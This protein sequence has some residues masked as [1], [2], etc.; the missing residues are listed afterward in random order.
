MLARGHDGGDG[1]V[2]MN[3]DYYDDLETRD[4]EARERA[5]MAALC[6]QVANAKDNG[7][8]W[9]EI[10]ADVD[11]AK[12]ALLE[13]AD[14][15]GFDFQ[16]EGQIGSMANLGDLAQLIDR[17]SHVVSRV[18]AARMIKRKSANQLGLESVGQI[19]GF[20]DVVV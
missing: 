2:A 18:G 4:A 9:A 16:A 15:V 8:A 6:G 19:A 7:P 17:L 5:L 1:R 3:D 12:R 11:A 13:E 10:L 20:L 14:Q